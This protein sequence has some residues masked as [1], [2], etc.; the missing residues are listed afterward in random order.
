[1]S[2]QATPAHAAAARDP[3]QEIALLIYTQLCGRIY[4]AS[5]TEKPQPKAVVQLSFRLAEAFEAGNLEF[6]PVARAAREAKDKAGVNMSSVEIDF[7]SF[8]KP[9]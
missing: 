5:G 2:A 7:A 6:N 4:S 8:G 1:M 3:T 9:K